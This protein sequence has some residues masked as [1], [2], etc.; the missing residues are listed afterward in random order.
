MC[1]KVCAAHR[2]HLSLHLL[3]HCNYS[4][5]ISTVHNPFCDSLR[6]S[7]PHSAQHAIENLNG[8]Q[9]GNK[10]LK[11]QY[12]ER[13]S[14]DVSQDVAFNKKQITYS[15]NDDQYQDHSGDDS[16]PVSACAP[17]DTAIMDPP[18]TKP[19]S[20]ISPSASLSTTGA[21]AS[22]SSISAH[23]VT[24]SST[25]ASK[26]SNDLSISPDRSSNENYDTKEEVRIWQQSKQAHSGD[27]VVNFVRL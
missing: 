12:K 9:V 25:S 15:L 27:D 14:K 8:C 7:Q 2:Q 1:D 11:V 6:S 16:P 24:S 3:K 22:F 26:T 13:K 10:R 23:S 17:A 18:S 19:V 4:W 5:V 20:P 21:N